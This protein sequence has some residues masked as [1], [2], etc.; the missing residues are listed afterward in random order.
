MGHDAD[1]GAHN[2]HGEGHGHDVAEGI[3]WEHDLAEVDRLT[4]TATMHWKF[5]DRTAGAGS[6]TID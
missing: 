5:V 4:T 6:A 2:H 1:H 3:E